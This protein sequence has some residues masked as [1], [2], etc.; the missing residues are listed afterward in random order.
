MATCPSCGSPLDE[1]SDRCHSCGQATTRRFFSAGFSPVRRDAPAGPPLPEITLPYAVHEARFT[2]GETWT[3]GL[4]FL[5]D[6]GIFFLSETDGPWTPERLTEVQAHDPSKVHPAGK[7][8]EFV[9][10]NRIVRFKHSRLTSFSIETADGARPVR[11]PRDGW[12]FMDAYA[13]KTGIPSK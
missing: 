13:A 8:S 4:L 2:I 9:P 3:H 7:L 6:L 12:K 10:L 1:N 5:T 11:L